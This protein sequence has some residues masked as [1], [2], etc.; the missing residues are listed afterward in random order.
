MTSQCPV[1]DR[2]W[3]AR[4]LSATEKVTTFQGK[5]GIDSLSVIEVA[6]VI[7]GVMTD[8]LLGVSTF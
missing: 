1:I 2:N 8:Q 5:V 3:F 4:M 6:A 7:L